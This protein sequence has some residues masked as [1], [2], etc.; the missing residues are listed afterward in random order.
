MSKSIYDERYIGLIAVLKAARL[1]AGITQQQVAS[2]LAKPQSYVA[3][4][5]GRERRLDVIEFLDFAKSINWDPIP[6]LMNSYL[7]AP[8]SRSSSEN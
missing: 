2:R 8:D 4:V 1:S 6:T 7:Q 3:K 5:E